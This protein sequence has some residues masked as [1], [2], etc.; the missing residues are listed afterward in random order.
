M[1]K[2]YIIRLLYSK[3]ML[4]INKNFLA[5]IL[6]SSDKSV[7]LRCYLLGFPG[8]SVV[9]RWLSGKEA[10]CQTRDMDWIPGLGRSHMQ[11]NS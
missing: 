10:A 7:L 4:D 1:V 8:G 3:I 5:Y 11:W 9:K 6:T 2:L